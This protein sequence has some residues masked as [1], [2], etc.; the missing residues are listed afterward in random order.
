MPVD[1]GEALVA[2]AVVFELEEVGEFGAAFSGGLFGERRVSV[3]LS[4]RRIRGLGLLVQRLPQ[5]AAEPLWW[6][7][8]AVRG[9]GGRLCRFHEG[10]GQWPLYCVSP[11]AT[12]DG[13]CRLHA[14]SWRALYERCAQGDE[15]AC[16]EAAPPEGEEFAVYALDYGGPRLKVGLTQRWRLEWRVAEQ[17]HTAA[18][19]VSTGR[20]AEMRALER[21]LG[22]S[23]AASEGA[24]VKVEERL[25]RAARAL[26]RAD[27]GALAA[28]LASLLA[29]LGLSGEYEA[30]TVL[31]GRLSPLDFA[32]EVSG[33]EALLGKRARLVDYWAGRLAVEVD[34]LLL[35]VDKRSLLHT[36][37]DAAIASP[38][39]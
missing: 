11:A 4:V 28:R 34:G 24:G 13:Y 32:G 23:R 25:E 12:R 20:L 22:R 10:G 17:P 37:L 35:L 1:L 21:A 38:A 26:S 18:A 6:P 15:A 33:P 39:P 36:A 3:R 5:R 30:L 27:Y 29:E 16:E 19:L 14:R 8:L 2:R 31:P 9:L 7:E